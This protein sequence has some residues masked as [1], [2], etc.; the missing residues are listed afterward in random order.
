[1][2]ERISDAKKIDAIGYPWR[3]SQDEPG[4]MG[5]YIVIEIG[6]EQVDECTCKKS[7]NK[8]F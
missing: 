5:D 1:M 6:N 3:G 8:P 7:E 4:E 2:I